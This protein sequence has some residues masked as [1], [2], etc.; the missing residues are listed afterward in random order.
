M[1][2]GAALAY[3]SLWL[4]ACAIASATA[5]RLGRR[6]EILGAD[7]WRFLLRPWKLCTFAVA[8]AGMM[9][10]AP[11]T[12]DWSWTYVTGGYMSALAFA[13]APWSLGVLYRFVRGWVAP[14]AAFVAACVWMF[15]ASWSYDLYIWLR[16]GVYPDT[17]LPN[18]PASSCLYAAAGLFWS[19][20]TRGG[21]MVF[22][23]TRRDWFD[24]SADRRFRAV[25][26]PACLLMAFPAA[27]VLYFLV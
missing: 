21:R 18:I 8:A 11:Y 23:F 13:T 3:T 25:A 7:Y 24:P 6:L 1:S 26:L 12:G 2:T 19:L 14:A 20:E 17:W 10:V 9:G 4:L 22:A 5:V 16:D 15:S 27:S